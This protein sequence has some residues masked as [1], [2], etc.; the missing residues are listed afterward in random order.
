[1]HAKLDATTVKAI[2]ARKGQA[3]QAVV[4]SEFK[5]GQTAV[6]SI[7]LGKLWRSVTGM[8]EHIPTRKR[9]AHTG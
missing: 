8:P 7:W 1:M 4:A 2:F 5:V 9:G 3:T 6:S